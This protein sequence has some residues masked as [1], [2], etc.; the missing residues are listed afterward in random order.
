MSDWYNLPQ[1]NHFCDTN[2]HISS[3]Q[4]RQTNHIHEEKKEISAHYNLWQTNHIRDS[5]DHINSVQLKTDQSHSRKQ[6]PF[7]LVI[8]YK[9]VTFSFAHIYEIMEAD[10][11]FKLFDHRLT[12]YW[13]L[14]P[15]QRLLKIWYTG[16]ESEQDCATTLSLNSKVYIWCRLVNNL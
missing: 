7:Q 3:L 16:M 1:T 12:V 9:P 11:N 10:S 13:W 8:A 6:G 5:E 2:D 15:C 4:L 14:S